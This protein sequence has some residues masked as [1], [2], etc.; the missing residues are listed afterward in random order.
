MKAEY[1]EPKDGEKRATQVVED[2]GGLPE[3]NQFAEIVEELREEGNSWTEI[4][5][6]LKTVYN[7]LDQAAFEEGF[8]LVAEWEVTLELHGDDA[9]IPTERRKETICAETSEQAEQKLKQKSTFP[10]SAKIQSSKTQQ[11]DVAKI[12]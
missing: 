1:D 4:Y 9:E 3:D 7:I 5:D 2:Q 8:D 10:P 12:D 11:T 6:R